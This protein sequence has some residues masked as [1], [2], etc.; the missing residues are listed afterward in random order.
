MTAP[1]QSAVGSSAEELVLH[2][3]YQ[4]I[5]IL[6]VSRAVV[7]LT[8]KIGQTDVS[9]EILAGLLL[10][11]SLFGA[12]APGSMHALFHP[13]TGPVFVGRAS[14]SFLRSITAIPRG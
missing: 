2:L 8:R 13:S 1:P 7:W 11:P 6:V 3:V 10:G 4:V 14:A 12:I 5:A 9:G